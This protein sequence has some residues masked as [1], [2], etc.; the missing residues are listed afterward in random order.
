MPALMR[1][2][3]QP[4]TKQAL[5]EGVDSPQ[6][7]SNGHIRN[8]LRCHIVVEDIESDRQRGRISSHIVHTLETGALIAVS[9]DGITNVLNRVV[10]KLEFVA[11]RVKHF[12][13]ALARLSVRSH[14]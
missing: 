14:G 10:R 11:V 7:D 5:E 13:L 12:A 1:Q 8:R 3:P 2:N 6:D 9:R 4:G